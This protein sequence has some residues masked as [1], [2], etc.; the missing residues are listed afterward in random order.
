MKQPV[1][2]TPA[3][4]EEEGKREEERSEEKEEEESSERREGERERGRKENRSTKA[5]WYLRYISF[6]IENKALSLP[7]DPSLPQLKL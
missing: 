2:S 6:I 7:S 1:R 3:L 5:M 4:G